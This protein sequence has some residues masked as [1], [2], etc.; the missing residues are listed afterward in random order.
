MTKHKRFTVLIALVS[1]IVLLFS[2]AFCMGNTVRASAEE[3]PQTEEVT[4]EK[5]E[6]KTLVEGFLAQLKAKY[7]ED[8]ETYY[9]AILT[10]WGSVEAYLLSLVDEDTPDA[11]ATGWTKFVKWLGEY[12]PIWASILAVA[13]I[14]IIILCGKKA[15]QKVAEWVTGSRGKFKTVFNSINKLYA[16]Q[17][18]Q[19]EALI[20][21]LGENDKFK[22]ERAALQA[23]VEE[24]KKD[25][26]V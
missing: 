9:N 6:L 1:V 14:I 8:Y 16:A 3:A 25:D 22:N 23:S 26:D 12:A 2:C 24:I 5:S 19:S 15:L 10:K 18:A 11:T 21:L 20:K 4:D 13:A 7:G 17:N